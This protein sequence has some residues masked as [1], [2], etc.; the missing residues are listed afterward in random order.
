M[1]QYEE[2]GLGIYM[3]PEMMTK[4]L[5]KQLRMLGKHF[6]SS[7]AFDKKIAK[8]LVKPY[9][10]SKGKSRYLQFMNQ[11]G[12]G[13]SMFWKSMLKKN[14]ALGKKFDKPFAAER[15]LQR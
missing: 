8:E 4:K 14:N 9:S 6:G 10:L 2:A 13:D 15:T 7:G 11:L 3:M 5:F 1:E 12:I